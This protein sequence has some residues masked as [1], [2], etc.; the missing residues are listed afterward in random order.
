MTEN[1][2]F[3][4]ERYGPNGTQVSAFIARLPM[5]DEQEWK[6]VRRDL[7][8]RGCSIVRPWLFITASWRFA[9]LRTARATYVSAA[10]QDA[11]TVV[12]DS[13]RA[14]PVAVRSACAALVLRDLLGERDFLFYY[15][16]FVSVIP[17]QTL[18]RPDS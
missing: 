12:A 15:R 5:L 13:G 9:R 8:R 14:D 4:P 3:P 17:H 6:T 7:A 2:S 16:G 1:T 18:L 10:M 11:V